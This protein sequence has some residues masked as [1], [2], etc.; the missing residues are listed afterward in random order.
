[1]WGGCSGQKLDLQPE[2]RGSS[3]RQGPEYGASDNVGLL[4]VGNQ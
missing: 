4:D 2:V 1:M 3:L